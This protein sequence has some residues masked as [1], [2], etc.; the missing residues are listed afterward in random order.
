MKH[1]FIGNII[2]ILAIAVLS[3]GTTASAVYQLDENGNIIHNTEE[4]GETVP[5]TEPDIEP[6]TMPDTEP[7]VTPA[8]WQ[9]IEGKKYY[10]SPVTGEMLMGWQEIEG[11][12][13]YFSFE[14]GEMLTG[15]QAEEEKGYYFSPVTGEMLTGWQII[16]NED[17]YFD[18][19]GILQT[20]GLVITDNGTYYCGE[21]GNFISGW[22]KIKGSKYYF[23][24][25]NKKMV[26]GVKKIKGKYY[27]FNKKGRLAESDGISIVRVK[28][29]I[30]CANPNGK[31][32]KGWQIKGNKLYNAT[33]K[34]RVRRNTTYQGIV[35]TKTGAAKKN[36][37]SQLK[38]KLIRI[39]KNITNEKMPKR[40]KLYSCWN[41]VTR[42]R[43]HYA[44]KYPD[45]H[46]SGWQK[47]TAYDMLSTHS[48][49]CYSYACAFA[50]LALEI[51]CKPYIVCGRVHGS[52][53]RAS[54]GY[55]RH[56]WVRINGKYY[57]PEAQYA[58]WMRGVYARTSY[59]ASHKI[60]KIV[61]YR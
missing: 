6:D 11:K 9:E 25:K 51:G 47:R 44:S 52:R 32:A 41:Y 3:R 4:I 37:N 60:Q 45:I 13:Y 31:A 57:D 16:D 54:D 1:R 26:T 42:G 36:V 49:N 28:E 29:D 20:A 5:E 19:N 34:G 10:I 12:E 17:Y 46:S 21:D 33:R 30:Y 58:G 15:W 59:P 24:T 23:A 22:K 18:E 38:I 40:G 8:G 35:F 27:I 55:T 39:V 43:F 61:A 2:C 50:A 48:G 7:D 53:D 14:T 56:A